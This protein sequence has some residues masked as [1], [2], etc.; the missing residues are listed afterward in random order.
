METIAP[1]ATTADEYTSVA[2]DGANDP[3][4]AILAARARKLAQPLAAPEA[5]EECRRVLVMAVGGEHYAIDSNAAVEVQTGGHIVAIPGVASMW[6]GL[7][8]LRGRLYPVLDL[9]RLLAQLR[10]HTP[11]SGG[12][13]PG[14]LVLA[15]GAG[16]TLAL[17]VDNVETVRQLARG[18]LLPSVSGHL[19]IDSSPVVGMTDD[20]VVLLDVDILFRNAAPA[21]QPAAA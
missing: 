14:Q 5:R 20:L 9:G 17:H 3:V 2:T 1:H 10:L 15:N 19:E 21:G 8:N 11:P 4:Q 18:T 12:R 6:L 13:G 7:V 16:L